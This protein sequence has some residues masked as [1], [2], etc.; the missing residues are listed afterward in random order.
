M[1]WLFLRTSKTLYLKITSRE[2]GCLRH[3]E[4][5]RP[6]KKLT[7]N[8]YRGT[9]QGAKW[10]K[11]KTAI[12]LI[13]HGKNCSNQNLNDNENFKSFNSTRSLN[14]IGSKKYRILT[15]ESSQ[16]QSPFQFYV[17]SMEGSSYDFLTKT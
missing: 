11:K 14:P 1:D 17:P 4:Y 8:Y 5:T 10:F 12:S 3:V 6:T 16:G 7:V 2:A 13:Y 15:K 9:F